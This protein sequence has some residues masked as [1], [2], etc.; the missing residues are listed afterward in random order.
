MIRCPDCGSEAY[1]NGMKGGLQRYLC[2]E[3]ECRSSFSFGKKQKFSYKVK[4][5]A[6]FLYNF[7]SVKEV[8]E[9]VG[10][11]ISSIYNWKKEE[12]DIQNKV[13]GKNINWEGELLHIMRSSGLADEST[14]KVLVQ[15]LPYYTC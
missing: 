11:R 5:L 15:R 10:C 12:K 2:K 9:I 7:R 1:K 8:S 4:Y 14:I 13:R 3:M 6:I